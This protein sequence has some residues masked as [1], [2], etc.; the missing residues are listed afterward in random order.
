MPP[1]NWADTRRADWR[2]LEQQLGLF[3]R[4]SFSRKLP[5]D[6]VT[7]Y[8]RLH[9]AVANDLL[10]ARAGG[11]GAQVVEYLNDLVGRS[12]ARL[13]TAQARS[14]GNPLRYLFSEAPQLIRQSKGYLQFAALIV[15]LGFVFGWSAMVNDPEARF[16]LLPSAHQGISPSERVERLTHPDTAGLIGTPQDGLSLT[17][18]NMR[19][20]LLAFVLG[21]FFG[22]FSVIVL[23]FNG[24]LLGAMAADYMLAGSQTSWFFWA[25]ILPHGVIEYF[26]ILLAGAAG[27]MLGR[28]ALQPGRRPTRESIA[29]AA[30]PALR[31]FLCCIPFF[32]LAGLIETTV[33]QIHP[34]VLPYANK[35]VF[36][37]CV[38]LMLFGFVHRSGPSRTSEVGSRKTVWHRIRPGGILEILTPEHVIFRYRLAGLVSRAIAA[39]YDLLL[40][41]LI[42]SPLLLPWLIPVFG[43]RPGLMLAIILL[44]TIC[45]YLFHERSSRSSP[46]KRA[47]G[48]KVLDARGL[49]L[50]PIQRLLRGLFRTIDLLPFMLFFPGF[51]LVGIISA[52]IGHGR[53]RIGDRVA[54]T[55]V[56]EEGQTA[57]PVTPQ[58]ERD[59][60]LEELTPARRVEIARRLSGEERDLLLELALRRHAL[61][62]GA[63]LSLFRRTRAY[64]EQRSGWLKPENLP[65]ERY[66]TALAWAV[67]PQGKPAKKRGAKRTAGSRWA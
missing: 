46:G 4:A 39:S 7:E 1:K 66:V 51:Y 40:I 64:F 3:E 63:R 47:M 57:L 26:A 56:I 59:W 35:L 30:G 29:E 10:V 9:R 18:H 54:G 31:L 6:L 19:L 12:Y 17:F 15:L 16:H 55:L 21:L 44:A 42:S 33:S 13:Y 52:L 36:A 50:T 22:V 49:G 5:A 58:M 23:F 60:Y 32:A 53:Q 48:L 24:V 37:L 43:W 8:A 61:E 34:P 38:A 41:G 62:L 45:Y 14:L 25:W 11:A 20:A 28:A 2:T 65:D 67:M 27:L